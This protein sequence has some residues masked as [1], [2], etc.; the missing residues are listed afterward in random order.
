MRFGEQLRRIINGDSPQKTK[1]A[2][3]ANADFFQAPRLEDLEKRGKWVNSA[4]DRVRVVLENGSMMINSYTTG[5]TTPFG[6]RESLRQYLETESFTFQP[7]VSEGVDE[8]VA[9][10]E[11]ERGTSV[12]DYSVEALELDDNL[13]KALVEIEAEANRLALVVEKL[14]DDAEKTRYITTLAEK[15]Q[16]ASRLSK[17]SDDALEALEG[18]EF[19]TEYIGKQRDRLVQLQSI[20]GEL[21]L[22]IEAVTESLSKNTTVE[23][24]VAVEASDRKAAAYHFAVGQVWE[25]KDSRF[26]M[27]VKGYNPDTRSYQVRIV[28]DGKSR[29]DFVNPE[30]II[31]S[32]FPKNTTVLLKDGVENVTPP[33]PL[34]EAIPAVVPQAET[35]Q[36]VTVG[37]AVPSRGRESRGGGTSENK[38]E[39]GKK[40]RRKGRGSTGGGGD[41]GGD[42]DGEDITQNRKLTNRRA[43]VVALGQKRAGF[44]FQGFLERPTGAK[45]IDTYRDIIF[46]EWREQN[47]TARL[48]KPGI[49]EDEIVKEWKEHYLP[50]IRKAMVGHLAKHLG[51]EVARADAIIDEVIHQFEE[52]S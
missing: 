36:P 18:K 50:E 2:T 51:G 23:P 40:S 11:E 19:T 1:D 7:A 21:I 33:S 44:L 16:M 5:E 25:T 35:G 4:G 41:D 38:R 22:L 24:E 52:G 14:D 6:D 30:E 46:G 10:A 8:K 26:S 17:E 49:S 34:P 13:E 43:R 9:P 45:I 31:R 39:V 27:E 29:A 47:H 37:Q 12:I 48:R 20:I 28:K 32:I 15:T 42:D 3:A